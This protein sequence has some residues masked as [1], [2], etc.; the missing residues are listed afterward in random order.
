MSTT[1]ALAWD[2]PLL[3][4]AYQAWY[5]GAGPV[6]AVAEGDALS[7]AYNYCEAVTA[8]RSRTF[9]LASALLPREKRR[10]MRALYAFCRVTDDIVDRRSVNV[11][12]ALAAW[13]HRATDPN[14]PPDD[15]VALAWADT[16]ARYRIP[17]TYAEQLIDGV[18]RDLRQTRYTSFDELATYAYG[19]ASTVGLMSMHIIGFAGEAAIPYAVRLGVALQLINILR[20][21]GEDWRA[22]RLYLPLDELAAHGLTEADVAVGHVDERWR[23]FMWAQTERVR[24]IYAEAWPGIRLLHADGRFA[25]AAAGELYLGILDD[26][27]AHDFDVFD[28]RAHVGTWRKLRRL[29]CA[30]WRSR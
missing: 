11:G 6:A 10:A 4:R 8:A 26:I 30:W 29:P 23:T 13:R 7:A 15:P 14:P 2:V 17:S 28:R 18:A 20:D 25:V 5:A 12:G 27:E 9:S 19:V 3:A 16:R 24:R 22:G 1:P 21:V